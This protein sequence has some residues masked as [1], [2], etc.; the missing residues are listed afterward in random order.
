MKNKFHKNIKK[1]I[2][3]DT[4]S[5]TTRHGLAT[6]STVCNDRIIGRLH[7]KN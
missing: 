3:N 4:K 5:V 7:L 6:L 1:F 2:L